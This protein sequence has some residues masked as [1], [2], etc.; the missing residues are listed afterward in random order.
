M[1][2]VGLWGKRHPK[3]DCQDWWRVW[4]AGQFRLNLRKLPT[5][6]HAVHTAKQS[7]LEGIETELGNNE[8]PLVSELGEMSL[9]EHQIQ[10]W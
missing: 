10:V 3:E 6:D 8:L 5:L 9:F 1:A 4:S 7:R 2:D